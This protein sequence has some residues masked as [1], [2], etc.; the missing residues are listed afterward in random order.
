MMEPRTSSSPSD[1]T[2]AYNSSQQRL[3]RDYDELEGALLPTATLVDDDDLPSE[4]QQSDDDP[5]EPIVPTA[6]PYY[7]SSSASHRRAN[8]SSSTTAESVQQ[9]QQQSYIPYASFSS[10]PEIAEAALDRDGSEREALFLPPVPS[11]DRYKRG[12]SE[13]ELRL[14]MAQYKGRLESHKEQISVERNNH[15]VSA[16]NNQMDLELDR[17]NQIAFWENLNEQ[18]LRTPIIAP[19]YAA[20]V[21]AASSSQ[22]CYKTNNNKQQPQRTMSGHKHE[23][24]NPNHPPHDVESPPYFKKTHKGGYEIKDYDVNEY[25]YKDD[26][27]EYDMSDY[28][29]DYYDDL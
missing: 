9:R 12:N 14:M 16:Y 20:A 13:D 22:P 24:A 17:A 21:A 10:Q 3:L 26:D 11:D 5:S 19:A 4:S 23:H 6:M 25:H 7:P 29:S 8:T 27:Y 15:R 18:A 2:A 1:T 28:K